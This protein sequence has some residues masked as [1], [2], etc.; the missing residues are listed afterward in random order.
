MKRRTHT[1][2]VMTRVRTTSI[3]SRQPVPL[4]VTDGRAHVG[5]RAATCRPAT[6]TT[7][8][9]PTSSMVLNTFMSLRRKR[10]EI[11]SP[12][13]LAPLFSS[14]KPKSGSQAHPMGGP[15]GRQVQQPPTLIREEPKCDHATTNP[16]VVFEDEH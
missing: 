7:G 2:K 11:R 5:H 10:N 6:C 8:R 16:R 1:D 9:R 3:T 15:S 12:T 14:D 4:V 13:G